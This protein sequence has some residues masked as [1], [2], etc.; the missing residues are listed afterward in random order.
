MTRNAARATK[1][2]CPEAA[3][4]G[5]P[6]PAR[7]SSEIFCPPTSFMLAQWSSRGLEFL[8]LA[9]ILLIPLVAVSRGYLVS[10]VVPGEAALLKI[11]TLRILVALMVILWM[12]E[13]SLSRQWTLTR[14]PMEKEARRK[15]YG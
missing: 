5:A 4:P 7:R 2:A 8:W 10:E 11:A 13:W 6:D 9:A 1:K 15:G 14:R 3:A 12:V